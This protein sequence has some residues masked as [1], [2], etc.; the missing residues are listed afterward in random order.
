MQGEG[1]GTTGN[2]QLSSFMLQSLEI[3]TLPSISYIALSF[4]WEKEWED[5]EDQWKRD[6]GLSLW[7]SFP[8]Y[9]L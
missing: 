1:R 7:N 2:T 6:Q 9:I 5:T 8:W 4:L 3:K